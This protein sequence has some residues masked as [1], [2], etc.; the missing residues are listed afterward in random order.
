MRLACPLCRVAPQLIREAT[1]LTT[2]AGM[3]ALLRLCDAAGR[4]L[5]PFFGGDFHLI[6]RRG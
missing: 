4:R 3:A 5:A 6:A 1:S 2:G